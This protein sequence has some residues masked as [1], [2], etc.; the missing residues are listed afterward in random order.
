MMPSIRPANPADASAMAELIRGA[1]E[2]SF[3]REFAESGRLRFLSDHTSEMMIAR[4]ESGEF[5]YYLA[6]VNGRLVG[7]VG[8]RRKSHLFSLYVEDNM[9]RKGLG[10]L[11]WNHARA[12]AEETGKVDEFTVNSSKNAVPIYERFGFVAEGPIVDSHGVR[13]VPMRLRGP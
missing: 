10:R 8:L 12:R 6:E 4:L 11:L 13:Y 7:V 3:L 1:S 5:H 9:Q 2:R